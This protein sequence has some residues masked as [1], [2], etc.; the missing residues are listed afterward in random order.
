M[1][2][3][4][5]FV[6]CTGIDPSACPVLDPVP[7]ISDEAHRIECGPGCEPMRGA[8][9]FAACIGD[10]VPRLPRDHVETGGGP[11]LIHPIDDEEYPF[12]SLSS[13]WPLIHL[14][15]RY[16]GFDL[17]VHPDEGHELGLDTPID[18]FE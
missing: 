13:A 10:E 4:I 5:T 15:W 17:P 9:T 7:W 6:G 16:C 18:C 14:C 3:S 11:C 2:T 12:S 1:R 8:G